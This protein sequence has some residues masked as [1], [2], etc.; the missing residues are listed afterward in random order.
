MNKQFSARLRKAIRALGVNPTN[1]AYKAGVPQ[2]T[3]SKCLHGH[4]PTA[5]LLLRI[6]RTSGRSVDWLLT[7]KER[8]RSEGY[9]A[10]PTAPYGR[11]KGTRPP[12]ARGNEDV[13][14]AKLLKVLRSGSRRKKQTVKD[15]LDVLSR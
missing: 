12:K 4:V 13:W 1:F 5:K 9:V 7:G 8:V 11:R 15:L 6:A 3:I 10:E 14:V 2:G